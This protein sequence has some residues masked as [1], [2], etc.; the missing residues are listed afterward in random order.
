MPTVRSPSSF[1]ARKMRMAISLRLAASNFWMFFGFVIAG[2]NHS[3][4]ETLY[5]H[6]SGPPLRRSFF[7]VGGKQNL[8]RAEDPLRRKTAQ[9][10]RSPAAAPW[11]SIAAAPL[12]PCSTLSVCVWWHREYW[13]RRKSPAAPRANL[14]T[15]RQNLAQQARRAARHARHHS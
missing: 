3:S 5:F 11:I 13:D 2:A 9:S 8:S 6:T 7:N 4:R 14:G 15:Y 1:A 12:R 10:G